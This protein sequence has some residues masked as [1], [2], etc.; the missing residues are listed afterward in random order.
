M[1]T[2]GS[3][4][5]QF[6]LKV[7]DAYTGKLTKSRSFPNLITNQGLIAY[8]GGGNIGNFTYPCVCVGNGTST[9]TPDDT[10]LASHLVN[11]GGFPELWQSLIAPTAPDWVSGVSGTV[12]FNA[13]TFDGTT[14]SEIGITNGASGNP[15][16]CRALILDEQGLPSS[17]TVLANE[18][19]DVTYTLYYHPKLDDTEFQFQMAGVTYNCVARAAFISQ[20]AFGVYHPLQAY[21]FCFRAVYNTQTLGEITSEP[22]YESGGKIYF[23]G[24]Y[25]PVAY[26]SETPYTYKTKTDLYLVDG[27]F[28][29]GIGAALIANLS[30][31]DGN[32]LHPMTQVSFTPKLP[33]DSNTEMSFTLARTM[34]RWT[35]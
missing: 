22:V 11:S 13:G 23:L 33:K 14:L 34:A 16:W 24:N 27:N 21:G 12:R 5:G 28:D 26:A 1:M 17:V 4:S 9:P 10:T 2:P 20:N 30:G 15:V 19:L 31:N 6:D 29:G 3:I 35:P 8:C 18:Y 25:T 32:A 7:Y